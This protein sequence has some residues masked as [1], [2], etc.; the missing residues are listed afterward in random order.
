M[1]KRVLNLCKHYKPK[2]IRKHVLNNVIYKSSR[3][4]NS[5]MSDGDSGRVPI[6]FHAMYK[7]RTSTT[8]GLWRLRNNLIAMDP[9]D[10]DYLPEMKKP[11]P[12]ESWQS[13]LVICYNFKDNIEL[14]NDYVRFDGGIRFGKILEDMDALAGNIMLLHCDNYDKYPKKFV[15]AGVDRIDMN[16]RFPMNRNLILEGNIIY[17]GKSSATI[18]LVIFDKD[19]V[20]F[21]ICKANFI[22]AA[23]DGIN[24]TSIPINPIKLETDMDQQKYLK[25]KFDGERRKANRMKELC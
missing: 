21:E 23:R 5:I 13:S 18:E 1:F 10:P 12:R 25:A 9:I 8:Q 2:L 22:M 14:R 19:D 17:T 16:R 3:M 11:E 4:F 7:N 20:T 15:T 24:N 6:D